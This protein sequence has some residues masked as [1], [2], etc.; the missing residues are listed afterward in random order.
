MASC[1][2]DHIP[3]G[4][5]EIARVGA[6]DAA[7]GERAGDSARHGIGNGSTVLL[8]LVVQRCRALRHHAQGRREPRR[9]FQI[10]WLG[11][12]RGRLHYDNLCGYWF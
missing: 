8:P 1:R 9:H 2:I 10:R 11:N 3:T 7:D 5:A 6:A 12:D 4:I